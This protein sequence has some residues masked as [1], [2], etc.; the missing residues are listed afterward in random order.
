M[1]KV[2]TVVISDVR[3]FPGAAPIVAATISKSDTRLVISLTATSMKVF[4]VARTSLARTSWA[5]TSVTLTMVSV[6]ISLATISVMSSAV[7]SITTHG[8]TAMVTSTINVARAAMINLTACV[9]GAG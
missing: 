4:F 3:C 9:T 1:V 5:R 2:I 8:M 7:P 6:T